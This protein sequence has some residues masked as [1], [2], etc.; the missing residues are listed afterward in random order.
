LEL[1]NTAKDGL[2]MLYML[3]KM[4]NKNFTFGNTYYVE[5]EKRRRSVDILKLYAAYWSVLFH[6]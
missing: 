5:Y 2:Y 3:T 1:C 4:C 6:R